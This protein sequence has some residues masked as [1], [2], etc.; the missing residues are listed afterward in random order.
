VVLSELTE[1]ASALAP[2]LAERA[3]DESDAVVRATLPLALHRLVGGAAPA[4]AAEL[5][6]PVAAPLIRRLLGDPSL[7]VRHQAAVAQARGPDGASDAAVAALLEAIDRSAELRAGY[8]ALPWHH[9]DGVVFQSC[10][11]LARWAAR[12]PGVIDALLERLARAHDADALDLAGGVLAIGF[13]EGADGD[14]WRARRILAAIVSHDGLWQSGID[15]ALELHDLPQRRDELRTL[16]GEEHASFEALR[17]RAAALANPPTI[18]DEIR[19]LGIGAP[20]SLEAWWQA[21]LDGELEVDR[22]ATALAA[23]LDAA[24]L[25]DFVWRANL[26]LLPGDSTRL[27]I[28]T[29]SAGAARDP[30]GLHAALVPFASRLARDGAP[31]VDGT[32]GTTVLNGLYGVVVAGAVAACRGGAGPAA[33]PDAA[34]DVCAAHVGHLPYW[35][36]QVEAYRA[37]VGPARRPR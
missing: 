12:R 20:R 1:E 14:L 17:A 23:H 33:V 7:L 19:D 22:L 30:A 27:A 8:E 3:A 10:D 2:F 21:G 28:A 32:F 16:I 34:F 29:L 11:T 9:G 35:Q 31:R 37:L 24:S 15:P 13:G 4:V 25:C 26:L 18:L 5:A 6:G 36:E